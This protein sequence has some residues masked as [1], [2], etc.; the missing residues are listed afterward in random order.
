MWTKI[1][2]DFLTN[3][4][5]QTTLLLMLVYKIAG[6]IKQNMKYE[7][8]MWEHKFGKSLLAKRTKNIQPTLFWTAER[9]PP[10]LRFLEPWRVVFYQIPDCFVLKMVEENEKKPVSPSVRV[11]SLYFR[12]IWVSNL[13]NL[14]NTFCWYL[15]EV[16]SNFT[17]DINSNKNIKRYKFTC[18]VASSQF[19]SDQ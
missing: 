5:K 15:N 9:S 12:F 18:P 13:V 16:L 8:K 7:W 19:S 1:S 11:Q 17:N 4:E 3:N 6:N 2:L 14:Q 10:R